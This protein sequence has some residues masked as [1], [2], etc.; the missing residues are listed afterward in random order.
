[1]TIICTKLGGTDASNGQLAD[2]DDVVE[3]FDVTAAGVMV[4]DQGSSTFL[5]TGSGFDNSN[6]TIAISSTELRNASYLEI[7][8]SCAAIALSNGTS[9]SSCTFQVE[10]NETG[11]ASFSDVLASTIMANTVSPVSNSDS[12]R[13]IATLRLLV[14]LTAGEKT[15]GIDIKFTG[16]DG[17]GAGSSATFSNIQTWFRMAN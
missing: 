15:N 9:N 14:I 6:H 12:T 7:N 3:T 8:I 2:V 5:Y 17:S 4:A 10:R 16:T 11:Q 1:M 13:T